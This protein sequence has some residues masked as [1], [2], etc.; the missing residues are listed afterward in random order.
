MGRG[1]LGG[2]AVIR[3]EL[4]MVAMFAALM[5][6]IALAGCTQVEAYGNAAAELR[7]QQNDLQA[8]GTIAQMCDLS[9]GA[10]SRMSAAEREFVLRNPSCPLP[11]E[12]LVMLRMSETGL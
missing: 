12:R 6:A 5:A 7:R 9:I 4:G 10:V 1:H 11:S 3:A 8:R 2:A